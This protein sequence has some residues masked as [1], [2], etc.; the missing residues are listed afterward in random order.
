[1]LPI[2]TRTRVKSVIFTAGTENIVIR[3]RL[4]DSAN[5]TFARGEGIFR[6]LSADKLEMLRS[7]THKQR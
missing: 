1:M 2:G 5:R 7:G 6:V 4:T 3:S